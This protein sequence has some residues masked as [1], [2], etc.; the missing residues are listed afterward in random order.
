MGARTHLDFDVNAAV[1]AA[2]ATGCLNAYDID[3][4][5]DT[6][7][8][9]LHQEHSWLTAQLDSLQE[10]TIAQA[11][12]PEAPT[13]QALQV[14]R[15]DH[16]HTKLC[17]DESVSGCCMVLIK[18]RSMKGLNSTACISQWYHQHVGNCALHAGADHCIA[19]SS[20]RCAAEGGTHTASV[21]TASGCCKGYTTASA[22]RRGHWSCDQ[23][24]M[25]SAER[26]RGVSKAFA[27]C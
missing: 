3:A 20:G 14:L 1:A 17:Q 11:T 12:Q 16:G 5:A 10:Q 2:K 8:S 15:S 22:E 23:A 6:L 25:P 19:A 13:A 18:K 7:R 24:H 27:C 26:W 21:R 4:I 9:A